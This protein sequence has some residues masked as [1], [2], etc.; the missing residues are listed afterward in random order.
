MNRI[1]NVIWSKTKKCYVVVSE[2]VKSSGGKV[3]S[4][5]TGKTYTHMSTVMAVA[6]LLAGVNI[7]SVNAAAIMIDGVNAGYA[8]AKNGGNQWSYLYNYNNPGNMSALDGTATTGY[9]SGSALNGISIGHNTKIQEASDPT[10]YSGVAIGDYAQ[11]T[12]GLSFSLGNYAQSTKPSAMAIGTASLSS[13][14]NS[15]A[16]MRQSAATGNFSTAIGTTSWASGT[17]SFALGYSAQSKGGSIHCHR[18][19]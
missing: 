16:M 11:A 9:Y 5:H 12:G 10:Y 13:G 15:L 6:A 1:Y 8:T 17:G 2:I 7:T 4:L 3:K 14:F 18:C 19:S